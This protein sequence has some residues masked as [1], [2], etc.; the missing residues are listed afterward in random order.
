MLDCH[1]IHNFSFFGHD[2]TARQSTGNAETRSVDGFRGWLGLGLAR[3]KPFLLVYS[4]GH[5]DCPSNVH[6]LLSL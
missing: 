1:S 3:E 4:L 5:C 2:Y 6:V